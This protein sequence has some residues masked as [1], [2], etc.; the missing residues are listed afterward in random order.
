MAT[1][2]LRD[3]LSQIEEAMGIG[4]PI[5]GAK[6]PDAIRFFR[7][8]TFLRDTLCPR[9]NNLAKAADGKS[10]DLV[11]VLADLIVAAVGKVPVPAATV[12]RA[13]VGIGADRFC[14]NPTA[15]VEAE[16]LPSDSGAPPG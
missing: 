8:L 3:A 1:D 4:R 12:A 10:G 13:I 11:V 6:L 5:G 9:L 14:A 16:V 2:D 7:V 15:L